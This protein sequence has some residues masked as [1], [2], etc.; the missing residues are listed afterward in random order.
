MK[1]EKEFV[2][3]FIYSAVKQGGFAF[4]ISAPTVSGLPDL[5]CAMPGFVPVLLE[6]KFIK[7]VGAKFKRKIDYSMLQLN[8]MNNVNKVY[9]HSDDNAA[10]GLIGIRTDYELYCKLMHPG[11]QIITHKD[12]NPGVNTIQD[13]NFIDVNLL[14]RHVVLSLQS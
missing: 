6:A 10:F 14:F 5:Y 12:L 11:V 13:G 7:D 9:S 4:K 1:S 2:D 8:L 3:C